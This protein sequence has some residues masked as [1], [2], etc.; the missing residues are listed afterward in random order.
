MRI[1]IADDH[2]L[3]LAGV[4]KLLSAEQNMIVVGDA[5]N[6]ADALAKCFDLRPDI[7]LHGYQHARTKQLRGGPSNQESASANQS[8]LSFN[9]RRRRLPDAGLRKWGVRVHPKTPLFPN[10]LRPYMRW[11]EATVISVPGMVTHLVEDFQGRTMREARIS[12]PS[13]LTHREVQV[14][15][16][17]AE[18]LTVKEIACDLGVELRR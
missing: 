8:Y 10:C 11:R 18:G 14:L 4:A 16:S 17:L 13:T 3:F 2:R 6:G 9:V 5:A 15:K 7:V 1:V 12:R